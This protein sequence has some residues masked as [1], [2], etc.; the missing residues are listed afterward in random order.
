MSAPRAGPASQP[1]SGASV[2]GEGVFIDWAGVQLEALPERALWWPQA[3]T[4]LLA[5]VHVGKAQSFRRLGVPVPRGTTDETLGRLSLLLE[6]TGAERLVV[7]GDWGHSA[8]GWSAAQRDA[9][10]VWRERHAALDWHLIVG[11]HDARVGDV[12][13]AWQ[14]QQHLDAWELGPL[15]L[16]HEPA[17]RAGRSVLAGH[18]HPC[19]QLDRGADRAR[20]PC[21]H[22]MPGLAVLPAFGAFTGMHAIRRVAGDRVVVVADGEVREVRER[23][24]PGP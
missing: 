24:G 22:F 14:L 11:N 6:R 9:V 23:R 5:D 17:P 4:L 7:L 2:A 13:A 10:S 3:S 12:P 18:L 15:T 20:L 21:F 16:C 1:A 8:R 19:L